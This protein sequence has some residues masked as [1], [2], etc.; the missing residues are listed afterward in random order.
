M[1]CNF[2]WDI[3]VLTIVEWVE[4]RQGRKGGSC[5]ELRSVRV[6]RKIGININSADGHNH[7]LSNHPNGTR[8][9]RCLNLLLEMSFLKL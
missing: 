3:E 6:V 8:Y 4:E 1:R 2:R 9:F 7:L 5:W